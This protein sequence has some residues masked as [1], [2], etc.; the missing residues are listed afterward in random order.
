MIEPYPCRSTVKYAEAILQYLELP[1]IRAGG[2][3]GRGRDDKH[4][5]TLCDSICSNYDASMESSRLMM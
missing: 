3:V 1:S 2:P 4:N 5:K